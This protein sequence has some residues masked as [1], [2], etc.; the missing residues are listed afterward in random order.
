[1]RSRYSAHALKLT[2]YILASWA[3]QSRD[4]VDPIALQQWLD[5]ARFTG[6]NVIECTCGDAE[7]DN[8]TV[9]FE[10]F[11]L[12][13]QQLHRHHELAHFCR[14]QG[15]W[16]YLSSQQPRRALPHLSRNQLCPCASGR[17]LKHCCI[18]RLAE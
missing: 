6:L 18:N 17:K 11:Y 9:E 2:P 5:S 13:D 8:G 15:Q 4:Q 3:D 7:D 12:Q 16:R 14:D 1:M 10:A